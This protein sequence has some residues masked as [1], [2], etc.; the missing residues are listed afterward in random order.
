MPAK[1]TPDRL[2]GCF[3]AREE[4]KRWGV[5]TGSDTADM[6]AANSNGSIAMSIMSR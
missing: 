1:H 6:H 2:M 3:F 4:A 5:L